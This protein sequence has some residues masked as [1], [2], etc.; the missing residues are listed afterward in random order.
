MT[1][2]SGCQEERKGRI[3]RQ[4]DSPWQG[5]RTRAT[6][7]Y[8]GL[9]EVY[10][11]CVSHPSKQFFEIVLG[12]VFVRM[13]FL[14]CWE[15]PR[16]VTTGYKISFPGQPLQ[17]SSELICEWFLCSHSPWFFKQLGEIQTLPYWH[18]FSPIC[19]LLRLFMSSFPFLFDHSGAQRSQC[20]IFPPSLRTVVFYRMKPTSCF[21]LILVLLLQLMI[22]GYAQCSLD[23]IVDKKIKEALTGLG[24]WLR[25]GSGREPLIMPPIPKP[26]F[27]SVPPPASRSY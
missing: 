2:L 1:A 20:S 10:H 7:A 6:V 25:A 19:S 24:N 17:T 15:V 9:T 18:W 13:C 11:S 14:R 16:S 8:H 26:N 27:F 23:S 21:L 22:P 5:T 12:H 4:E 3:Q